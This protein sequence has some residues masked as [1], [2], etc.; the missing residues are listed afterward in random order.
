MFRPIE[1][2]IRFCPI[3]LQKWNIYNSVR[4]CVST[5]RSQHLL[6]VLRRY[7]LGVLHVLRVLREISPSLRGCAHYYLYFHFY[8]S[9][10]QNL[11]MAS[12][13]RNM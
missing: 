5:V 1:A 7:V 11:M 10:G 2:I 3:E 6:R 9:I 4:N 8:S 12:I 13:G